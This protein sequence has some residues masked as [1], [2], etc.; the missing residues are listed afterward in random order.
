MDYDEL[1]TIVQAKTVL[2][3]HTT[4]AIT[5]ALAEVEQEIK[6][7]CNIS[8]VPVALK[9][10]WCNMT[11]DLL[12]Y[13]HEVNLD[14]ATIDDSLDIGDAQTIKVGDTSI[15]MG[16]TSVSNPRKTSLKSH[17]AN[18]DDVTMNYRSQLNRFRRL[19]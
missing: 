5:L 13:E 3:N 4:D 14:P 15:Q 10:T 9:F 17:K 1:T 18:L 12:N 8:V 16:G 7:Y 19:W 2:K 11:V 6:N